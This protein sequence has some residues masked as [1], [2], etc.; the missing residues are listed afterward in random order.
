[1]RGN[2]PISELPLHEEVWLM[3]LVTSVRERRTQQGKPFRD[4]SARNSTGNLALR[5]WPEVLESREEIRPGLWGVT[6]KVETF[7]DR[8]QFVV[9]EYKPIT[10]EK[11]REH[12]KAEPV[13]PRAFT[14]DIETLALP[15]F[16]E[17]V[18]PKLEKK[19]RR[20]DMRLEQQ[21]RYVE[22]TAAEEQRVYQQGSLDATSGRVLSIAVHVGAIP[23][24]KIEGLTEAQTEYVLRN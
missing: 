19:F 14:I 16:R 1:M 3:V 21:Q 20:G 10:I 18:G 7:Q 8:I 22:D 17:R 4:V 2:V 6:G 15:G 5:I 24:F 23:E 11:Y 9:S 12:Q 13:L